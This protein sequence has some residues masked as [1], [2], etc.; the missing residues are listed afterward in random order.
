M[1]DGCSKS[2][3]GK[4]CQGRRWMGKE[5]SVGVG[6]INVVEGLKE[7]V[8]G[9]WKTR[10]CGGWKAAR[11]IKGSW[12]LCWRLWRGKEWYAD[13]R[14]RLQIGA[15]GSLSGKVRADIDTLVMPYRVTRVWC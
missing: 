11:K 15:Q 4:R 5:K 7:S 13:V 10:C 12:I 3:D 6:V 1:V 9:W 14:R 2:V 8:G